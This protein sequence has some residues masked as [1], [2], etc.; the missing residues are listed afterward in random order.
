LN[1]LSFPLNLKINLN[2]KNVQTM[3]CGLVAP[4]ISKINNSTGLPG[5]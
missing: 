1:V 4:A 3:K 5:N 2:I